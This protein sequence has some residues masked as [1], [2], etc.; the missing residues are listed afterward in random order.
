MFPIP[1]FRPSDCEGL[2]AIDIEVELRRDGISCRVAGPFEVSASLSLALEP[3]TKPE[4]TQEGVRKAFEKL[5]GTD[6]RLGSLTVIDPDGLFAPMSSLNSLRREI[7]EKLDEARAAARRKKVEAALDAIGEAT[8]AAA[9]SPAD[10]RKTGRTLKMRVG[11]KIPDGDWREVVV[12]VGSGDFVE[13]EAWLSEIEPRDSLRLALPVYTAEPDFNR[14]RSFVKRLV[15][16]GHLKWEASDLATLRLLKSLEISDITADWTLAAF[17]SSALAALSEAGVRGF[18]ASPENI[19]PNMQALAESGY[20]V[21]FLSQQSTPL[22]IS[23]TKPEAK[24]DDLG[25]NLT[26][27]SRGGLWVTTRKSPRTF[28]VPVG[29]PARIDISWDA[30]D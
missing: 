5:G 6:Y 8:H 12:A 1:S 21:E 23:L 9:A 13:E 7:V 28:D 11:Q 4:R 19:R 20:D 25:G 10:V 22:F 14:L 3:A 30:Y 16:G 15:R 17:N 26:F 27:F 18:V 24:P 29:T 2:H